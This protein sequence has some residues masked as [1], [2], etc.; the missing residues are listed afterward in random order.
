M[1]GPVV[2]QPGTVTGWPVEEAA[3]KARAT[4]GDAKEEWKKDDEQDHA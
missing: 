4:Y 3:G 2:T 1:K